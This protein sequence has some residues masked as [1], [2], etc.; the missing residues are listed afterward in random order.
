MSVHHAFMY[1]DINICIYGEK[2]FILILLSF[3]F[4]ITL[5]VVH[6]KSFAVYYVVCLVFMYCSFCKDNRSF[7]IYV[8][9]LRTRSLILLL[10]IFVLQ[11]GT[12]IRHLMP[13]IKF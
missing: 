8:C 13:F 2:P 4:K 6:I 5:F 7:C 11:K 3:I 9:S 1:L 10:C 12:S